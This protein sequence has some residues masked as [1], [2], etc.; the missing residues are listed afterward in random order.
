[1]VG[2]LVFTVFYCLFYFPA[3]SSFSLFWSN[4]SIKISRHH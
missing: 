4:S 2:C 3:V 1:L